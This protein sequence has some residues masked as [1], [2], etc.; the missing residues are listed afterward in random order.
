MGH[1]PPE[2][3]F[4]EIVTSAFEFPLNFFC[5]FNPTV[6]SFKEI[7]IELKS[8]PYFLSLNKPCF[9]KTISHFLCH[10][11]ECEFQ[12]IPAIQPITCIGINFHTCLPSILW[13]P[14]WFTMLNN[15]L[16]T[17]KFC[18]V[19]WL[20]LAHI[21]KLISSWNLQQIYEEL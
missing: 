10:Y 7:P 6:L 1:H 15:N 21:L 14:W 11:E 12:F 2:L 8:N 18:K 20:R 19:F 9:S 17:F 13:I 3:H 4:R 5:N 16:F